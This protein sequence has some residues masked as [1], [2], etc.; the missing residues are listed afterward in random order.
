M[1]TTLGDRL[2]EERKR[3]ALSQTEFASRCSTSQKVQTSSETGKQLPGS[4]YLLA[5]ASIGVDV[6][7]VLTGVR[8][9]RPPGMNH[10]ELELFN[11]IVD[12]FSRLSDE[13]LRLLLALGATLCAHQK[14]QR[15]DP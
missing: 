5:A 3:L 10:H 4:A 11:Q 13:Q 14:K 6:G 8:T 7:Y 12:L 15:G 1:K 9:V 2:R